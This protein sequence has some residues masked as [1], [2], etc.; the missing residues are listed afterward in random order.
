MHHTRCDFDIRHLLTQRTKDLARGVEVDLLTNS[1]LEQTVSRMA[2]TLLLIDDNAVQAAT[3]QTILK[4]AGYFVIAAL[5][6]AR[7]LEQ[8]QTGDFPAEIRLVITDHLMPGLNGAD[9]V[10]ALRKTHPTL[11]V[12]VISGLEE[13]EQAY[14]GLQVTFRMKP[15]LPDQLL[16]TVH[17]LVEEKPDSALPP[18]N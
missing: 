2:A 11:P 8:F 17:Q 10:R 12:M 18:I 5:N 6:P 15:L 1:P 9:F 14:D 7:A 16:A 3:R 4:R 13:A